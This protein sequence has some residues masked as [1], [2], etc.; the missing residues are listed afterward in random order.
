V[1]AVLDANVLISAI[2]S[3]RGSPARLLLAWQA[4]EFDVVASPKLLVELRRA[5]TYPK[6]E[7][8]V[9]PADAD[10]FVAWIARSVVIAPDPD[11]PPPVRS[12][13]PGD[14]YLLALA[15]AERAVLVSGDADLTALG[16]QF[17]VRTPAA[18]LAEL[19]LSAAV[20]GPAEASG[21]SLVRKRGTGS[22]G[23]GP[24]RSGRHGRRACAGAPA[25]S[26]R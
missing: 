12:V 7:R 23:R 14:D 10:A 17:P 6:L 25:R 19:R 3:P 1:R 13:D 22:R 15:A 11:G 16:G 9:P 26:P 21:G 18:F 5:L 24:F 4:G 8:L 20:N 2:L